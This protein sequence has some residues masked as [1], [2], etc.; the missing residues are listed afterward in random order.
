MTQKILAASFGIAIFACFDTLLWATA[1]CAEVPKPVAIF[2]QQHCVH[3]HDS[4]STNGGLVLEGFEFE[5]G[6]RDNF[7]AWQRIFERVRDGEMPPADEERPEET[8]IG[9]FMADLGHSLI[10]ADRVDVAS[11]GRVRGRRLTRVEYEHTVHDLLGIDI[12]LK[13]RLPD[14]PAT[15]GFQTVAEGQQMSHFQLERYLDVADLALREAFK[16]AT[17]GEDSFNG[18]EGVND[19]YHNLSHHGLNEDK[20]RQLAIVEQGVVSQ[21]GAFLRKLKADNLLDE[22]MVLLT[23]NLGNA[24][25][26]DNR[27]MPVLIA[28]GDFKHGQHLAFD[29][30]NNYPLPNL[31][32]SLL[33]CAGIETDRFSTSTGTMTGL[34]RRNA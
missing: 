2:L 28:G 19:G 23:S 4:N 31:C 32:V 34:E 29:Q 15:R 25:N 5:L 9:Q 21:W 1:H 30:D 10:A 13:E 24:S 16:R 22:T 20:L 14:D 17:M 7:V 11:L 8:S 3:C 12:P 26:H 18:I 33:Q 27:N 6:D